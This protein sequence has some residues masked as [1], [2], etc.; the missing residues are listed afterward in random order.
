MVLYPI[1]IW[2]LIFGKWT[3]LALIGIAGALSLVEWFRMTL[4]AETLVKSV[5]FLLI[6]NAYIFIGCFLFWYL[7][8]ELSWMM[9]TTILTITFLSDTGGYVFGNLLKG[10]KLAPSI[11]PNKTWSGALGAI[12]STVA[13][14]YIF[15]A[16]GFYEPSFLSFIPAPLFFAL[17]SVVAQMGD[18]LESWTKR[19]L[20][21]KD[22]GVLIP[23]HGGILDRLDSVIAVIYMIFLLKGV[24]ALL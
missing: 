17:I 4:K 10:P 23:G 3:T 8:T 7:S 2:C 21:A 16:L 5:T 9:M 24:G 22:S 11:S 6:G 20:N 14:G 1:V 12:C 13:G 19:Q 18:L 15:S